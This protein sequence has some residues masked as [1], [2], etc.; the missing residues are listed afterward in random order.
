MASFVGL[1][2]TMHIATE[3]VTDAVERLT[4]VQR[5]FGIRL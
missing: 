3:N 4:P 5:R 2:F 1:M